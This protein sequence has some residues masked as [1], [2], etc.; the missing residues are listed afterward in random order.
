[1]RRIIFF[2]FPIL[3]LIAGLLLAMRVL[4]YWPFVFDVLH[5]AS[6]RRTLLLAWILCFGTLH[7]LAFTVF[8]TFTAI[9]IRDDPLYV[10]EGL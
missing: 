7:L 5:T 2:L 3:L 9:R 8:L 1:M 10:N 4:V 6:D